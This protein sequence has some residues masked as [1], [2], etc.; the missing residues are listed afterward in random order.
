MPKDEEIEEIEAAWKYLELGISPEIV[1][2]PEEEQLEQGS[3]SPR[4]RF[5]TAG[6]SSSGRLKHTYRSPEGSPK[7]RSQEWRTMVTSESDPF[8]RVFD[9]L[10]QLRFQYN[11]LDTITT[12]ASKL[13][14]DYKVGN[15]KK[16]LKKL[17]A[18]DTK[19]LENKIADLTVELAVRNDEIEDLKK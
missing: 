15:I 6:T 11:N 14:G 4:E 16:E 19:P 13:L 18:V 7:F 8:W 5:G 1:A 10:E 12:R 9:D 3:P 2:A 17:Q